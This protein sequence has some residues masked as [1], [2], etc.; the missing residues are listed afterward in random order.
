MISIFQ[1]KQNKTNIKIKIL[2]E[3]FQQIILNKQMPT[4]QIYKTKLNG[5]F[6]ES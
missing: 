3:C 6:L 5:K 2:T 4:R 1:K